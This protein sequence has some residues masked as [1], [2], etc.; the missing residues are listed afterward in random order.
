MVGLSKRFLVA[1]FSLPKYMLYLDN[2]SLF[3]L[4]VSSFKD[5]FQSSKF[6]FVARDVYHTKKFIEAECSLLN[7]TNFEIVILDS[8]TKG[9]AESV[10]LAIQQSS[11]Q[12]EDEIFI[13]N[14]DSYY[15]KFNIDTKICDGYLDVFNGS[16]DHWSFAK[17][18]S[19]NSDRVIETIEKRRIS[20]HCS[21]GLYYFKSAN[22]FNQAYLQMYETK[23]STDIEYFIAPLYNY[24]IEINGL[25]L[26]NKI[27][28]HDIR[29]CGT[30]AELK[31]TLDNLIK[32]S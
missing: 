15:L 23:N 17:T 1:G 4:S 5:Y 22:L 7:L 30:P 27:E 24:L 11:T 31:Q 9:Q 18:V 26:I 6:I 28:N 20:D 16:G 12:E 25:V 14:I 3:N 13:F 19:E 8:L 2:L 29:F 10:Y 32:T 21:T